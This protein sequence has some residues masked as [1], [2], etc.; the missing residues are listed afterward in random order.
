VKIFL[1]LGLKGPHVRLSSQTISTTQKPAVLTEYKVDLEA[2][3]LA[4][5][6]FH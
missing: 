4:E 6:C 1:H 2:K 3:A 5:K